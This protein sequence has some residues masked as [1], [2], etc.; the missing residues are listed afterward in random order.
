VSVWVWVSSWSRAKHG[1]SV[2]E[3]VTVWVWVWVCVCVCDWWVLRLYCATPLLG[4]ATAPLNYSSTAL[5]L[6]YS[7]TLDWSVHLSLLLWIKLT[8]QV[9]FYFFSLSDISCTFTDTYLRLA[10]SLEGLT[11]RKEAIKVL[12]AGYAKSKCRN[13]KIALALAKLLFKG[14]VCFKCLIWY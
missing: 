10:M 14:M 9:Y 7:S 13:S 2:S 4:Y 6:Y 11:R 12:E 8:H 1:S 5:L 3:C